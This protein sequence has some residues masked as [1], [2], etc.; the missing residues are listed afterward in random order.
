VANNQFKCSKTVSPSQ[1]TNYVVTAFN[2]ANCTYSTSITIAVHPLPQASISASEPFICV[3][4][5][6]TLTATGTNIHKYQWWVF[7]PDTAAITFTPSV[8]T[9][10]QLIVTSLYGCISTASF[11]I[12]VVPLAGDL[13]IDY[14][15]P[16]FCAG[17]PTSL[18]VLHDNIQSYLWSTGLTLTLI[19]VYPTTQTTLQ[20]CWY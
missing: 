10:Y 17:E 4:L 19:T 2:S 11:N 20:C 14:S 15:F 9:F 3:G 12:S 16:F 8:N 1:T 13:Q 6:L 18:R 7:G 5:P